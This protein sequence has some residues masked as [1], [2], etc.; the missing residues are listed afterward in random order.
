MKGIISEAALKSSTWRNVTLGD[1][2]RLQRGHDLTDDDR[3]PGKVPV[4]GAAGMNGYHDTAI[5]KG[6]G[7]VIGRSGA[8]FGKAHYCPED[9]WPHNTGLYVT[10]FHGNLK[11]ALRDALLPK[12]LSGEVRVRFTERESIKVCT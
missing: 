4:M 8:S 3:R 12:L 7:V 6:P 11:T 9:Y 5:E 2:V 10:D 1:F